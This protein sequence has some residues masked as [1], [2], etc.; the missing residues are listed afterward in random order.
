MFS[1]GFYDTF[2]LKKLLA[3]FFTVLNIVY[4]CLMASGM[5]SC[6]KSPHAMKSVG[7]FREMVAIIVFYWGCVKIGTAPNS[8][9]R[10]VK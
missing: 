2:L 1:V 8:N 6:K 5:K 10:I 3:A 7:T 9:L 4:L